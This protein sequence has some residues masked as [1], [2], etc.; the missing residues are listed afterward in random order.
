MKQV[1]PSYIH[2]ASH[3]MK[4]RETTKPVSPV[5][6]KHTSRHCMSFFHQ[7]F[8]LSKSI[9][10]KCQPQCYH[11]GTG[12]SHHHPARYPTFVP[13]TLQRGLPS[14]RHPNR[15]EAAPAAP[16]YEV[17][18]M[19]DE[20][21][22]HTPPVL[23]LTF[24]SKKRNNVSKCRQFRGAHSMCVPQIAPPARYTCSSSTNSSSQ[25]SIQVWHLFPAQASRYK[26]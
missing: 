23:S 3:V 10:T 12:T 26:F 18:S 17:G 11:R 7:D 21:K 20:S 9:W 25:L 8:I 22:A 1:R 6:C 24:T 15:T 2:F 5:Q 16:A 13:H 19:A 4:M 14:P